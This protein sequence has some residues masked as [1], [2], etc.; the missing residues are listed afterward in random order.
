MYILKDGNIELITSDEPIIYYP[1]QL[2]WLIINNCWFSDP[3]KIYTVEKVVDPV[4]EDGSP[5]V[6]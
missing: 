6:I 4:I 3:E 2:A 5:D 1:T